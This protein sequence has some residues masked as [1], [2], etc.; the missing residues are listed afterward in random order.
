MKALSNDLQVTQS[1]GGYLVSGKYVR[2]PA[3]RCIFT[4]K[5]GSPTYDYSFNPTLNT[6]KLLHALQIEEVQSDSGKVLLKNQ[7][8]SVPPD[9]TGYYVDFGWGLNTLAGVKWASADGAVTPRLW[10]MSQ[11]DNSGAPKGG[12]PDL[13]VV[14]QLAGVWSAVLNVQP[15]RVGTAPYYQDETG[16][17]AGMTIYSVLEY[18]IETTLSTQ[19]GLT[20]TLDALGDQDDGLI[21][22][23]ALKPFPIVA[24]G[25]FVVGEVYR[26]LTVETTDYVTEQGASANTIGVQFT[27]IA[28]GTGTGTATTTLID[29]NKD[30]PTKFDTY[31]GFISRLLSL[32]NCKLRVKPGLGFKLI[33]PQTSDDVN[34]TYYSN[35]AFGHPFYEVQNQRLNMTPNHIEVY[36]DD[37][38]TSGIF[39]EWY[40]PD[41]YTTPPTYNGD[42]MPVTE[43]VYQPGFTTDQQCTDFAASLGKQ[44]KDVLFGGR[45]I[46]PMDSRTELWD[47]GQVN[48][49]RGL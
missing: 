35:M 45:V 27:A 15:L 31:G 26:I 10:V 43:T 44:K 11:L 7:D 28:A 39:G 1:A 17:M 9:L 41:H 47:R 20:F 14:F 37:D 12:I 30:T 29:F 18:L 42:F 49:S 6:N 46:V 16:A 38:P 5:S 36:G 19:T 13:Y 8:L 2:Q 24:S 33:Y 32:T 21:N 25:S 34:E 48:N 3:L 40:D 23:T 22:S 4:H